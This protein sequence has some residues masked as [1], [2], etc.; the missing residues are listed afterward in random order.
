MFYGD[1]AVPS[2]RYADTRKEIAF[3]KQ[4]WQ[5]LD[6]EIAWICE[7]KEFADA[8]KDNKNKGVEKGQ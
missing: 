2:L 6:V 1:T 5:N 4:S 7:G 8:N 3:L